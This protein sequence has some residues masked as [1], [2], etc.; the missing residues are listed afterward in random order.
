M[1]VC[2]SLSLSVFCHAHTRSHTHTH[3]LTL[4][5]TL[6]HTLTLTLTHAH[7][8]THS[9]SPTRPSCVQRWVAGFEPYLVLPKTAPP[10]DN[11]F[12][13]FGWN[14]VSHVEEVAAARFNFFVLPDAYIV[15]TPHHASR[16]LHAFRSHRAYRVC[17]QAIWDLTR[18]R[19]K[20]TYLTT[21]EKEAQGA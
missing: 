21:E 7:A 17:L 20:Q 6:T 14:K 5:L 18:E 16:D 13:G 11:M 2:R 19:I 10:F 3:T 4:T 1:C 9:H 15:H 12:L 8:L